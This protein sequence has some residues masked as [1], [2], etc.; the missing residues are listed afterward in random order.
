MA[1]DGGV[2]GQTGKWP[3]DPLGPQNGADFWYCED[4]PGW[5]PPAEL[6]E[7]ARKDDEAAAALADA[8]RNGVAT[9]T[10]ETGT[11]G[12]AGPAGLV[13]EPRAPANIFETLWCAQKTFKLH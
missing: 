3:C 7:R 1:C 6:R 2:K 8:Q 11:G 12:D 4:G 9:T 13:G 5:K 10:I